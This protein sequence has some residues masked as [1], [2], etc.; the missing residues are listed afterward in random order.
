[1][2]LEEVSALLFKINQIRKTPEAMAGIQ[3]N[4]K[5]NPAIEAQFKDALTISFARYYF[6]LSKPMNLNIANYGQ[7]L[8]TFLF[9]K[10]Y[11]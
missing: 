7:T 1:M 2:T 4:I 11:I 8:G 9:R 6:N 10:I 5:N 3:I